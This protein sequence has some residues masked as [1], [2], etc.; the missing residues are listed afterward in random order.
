MIESFKQIKYNELIFLDEKVVGIIKEQLSLLN[1]V[2]L[3]DSHENVSRV[4][5][6]IEE[7]KMETLSSTIS[8]NSAQISE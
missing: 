7:I 1:N 3:I 4:P 5:S 8:V 6:Q 2:E